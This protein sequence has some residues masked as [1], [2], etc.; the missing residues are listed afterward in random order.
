MS[1]PTRMP[2]SSKNTRAPRARSA[3]TSART[4]ALSARLW[5]TKKSNSA[6]DMAQPSVQVPALRVAHLDAG[7]EVLAPASRDGGGDLGPAGQLLRVPR[8][9]ARVD[10][11][12][13]R[14]RDV[15]ADDRG[16]RAVDV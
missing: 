10:H 14:A 4:H 5:L 12:R 9:Q 16:R 2:S 15:V 7:R 1:S 11:D 3:P 8:L 6:E 13:R